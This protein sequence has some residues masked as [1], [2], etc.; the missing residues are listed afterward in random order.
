MLARGKHRGERSDPKK[1]QLRQRKKVWAI[2]LSTKWFMDQMRNTDTGKAIGRSLMERF[3]DDVLTPS[4]LVT[5]RMLETD[6]HRRRA[7]L[8]RNWGGSVVHNEDDDLGFYTSCS[9]QG[10][11]RSCHRIWG[12]PDDGQEGCQVL[13]LAGKRPVQQVQGA[14][15]HAFGAKLSRKSA[16]F[17]GTH[18]CHGDASGGVTTVL[19]AGRP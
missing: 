4:R 3:R 16:V 10:C 5:A 6:S 1:S 8:R 19:P 14:L 17:G 15:W 11:H 9:H 12:G 2:W 13:Q 7:T 18:R